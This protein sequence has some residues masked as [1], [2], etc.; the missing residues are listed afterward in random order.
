[1]HTA[2]EGQWTVEPPTELLP[3]GTQDGFSE[4]EVPQSK[5]TV[6]ERAFNQAQELPRAI[7]LLLPH[8]WWM[9]AGFN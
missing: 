3:K 2:A 6:K 4:R 8:Q 7:H 1:M 9:T 5:T